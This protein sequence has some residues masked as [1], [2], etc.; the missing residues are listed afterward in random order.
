MVRRQAAV[1]AHGGEGRAVA[2]D[3]PQKLQRPAV[4]VMARTELEA[5]ALLLGRRPFRDCFRDVTTRRTRE[6]FFADFVQLL[7]S[8]MSL[9][10][11]L[12]LNMTEPDI[13]NQ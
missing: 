1:A 9:F 3:A 10:W 7:E 12:M 2:A 8:E 6:Q 11:T 4:L 13:W 5:V